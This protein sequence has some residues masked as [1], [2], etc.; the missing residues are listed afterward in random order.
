M[1]PTR[2]KVVL[3]W[4][5]ISVG[6]TLDE[7]VRTKTDARGRAARTG[8]CA[9]TTG[10]CDSTGD[11]GGSCSEGSRFIF[12]VGVDVNRSTIVL[13]LI[14]LVH[15]GFSRERCGLGLDVTKLTRDEILGVVIGLP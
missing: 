15:E 6:A 5:K 8:D 13:V 10:C 11:V 14:D 7:K 2:H 1:I 9:L 3:I 12:I 4:S